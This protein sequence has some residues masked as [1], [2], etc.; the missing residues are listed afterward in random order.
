MTI[1]ILTTFEPTETSCR[2]GCEPYICSDSC[3]AS[4]SSPVP[5]SLEVEVQVQD[6]TLKCALETLLM[7]VLPL[8]VDDA[9]GTV[10]IWWPCMDPACKQSH[11]SNRASNDCACPNNH[12]VLSHDFD[13]KLIAV[14]VMNTHGE[15]ILCCQDEWACRKQ[16]SVA[17][18]H[19]AWTAYLSMH[20]PPCSSA[21]GSFSSE[22]VGASS[23]SIRSG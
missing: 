5:L 1:S 13:G 17:A 12:W 10:L 8:L 4:I 21:P 18:E 9:E 15:L 23:L 3:K 16:H 22:Y 11:T 2:T 20:V 7:A 19:D 6:A 14:P